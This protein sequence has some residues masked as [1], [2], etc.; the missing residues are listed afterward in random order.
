M[1]RSGAIL[2]SAAA[3]ALAA[4]ENIA[5]PSPATAR[6]ARARPNVRRVPVRMLPAT[7]TMRPPMSTRL[8]GQCAVSVAM[9]G[10]RTA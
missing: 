5:A 9:I 1:S 3:V 10:V 2:A 6:A 4:G 7:N 8:R